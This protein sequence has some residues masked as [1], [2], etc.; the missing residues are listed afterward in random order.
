MGL[1]NFG[2]LSIDGTKVRANASKHKAMSYGRMQE[3]ERRLVGEIEA[4]LASAGDADAAE[5]ARLGSD[6]RGDD[7]PVSGRPKERHSG[8]DV[9]HNM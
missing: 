4:L 5:D 1:A 3:E 2:K 6:E 9:D 7:L 8:R